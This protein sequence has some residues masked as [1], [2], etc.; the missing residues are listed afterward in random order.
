MSI[1][2]P[3]DSYVSQL[4]KITHDIFKNLDSNPP[5]ITRCIFPDMLKALDKVWHK[6][7]LFNLKTYGFE[8]NLLDLLIYCL[9]NRK[10]RI[11]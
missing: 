11:T 9:H 8:G 6:G 5:V 10:Q 1:W 3:E 4:L 7:L 2:F